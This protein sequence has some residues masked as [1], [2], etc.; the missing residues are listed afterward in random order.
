[1][2]RLNIA[3]IKPWWLRLFLLIIIGL[4]FFTNW[5][6]TVFD[7]EKPL[8]QFIVWL[9]YGMFIWIFISLN[10]GYKKLFDYLSF[11]F[12]LALIT[13]LIGAAF[14]H[15]IK[16][17]FN[18][19]SLNY[20]NDY[21]SNLI[22]IFLLIIIS[23]PYTLFFINCFSVS[24][25]ISRLS[26]S[27]GRFIKLKIHIAFFL[28]V[29]Q[30]TIEVFIELLE[31]WK[32]ENPEQIKPRFREDWQTSKYSILHWIV[33][34]KNTAITWSFGLLHNTFEAVQYIEKDIK[35]ILTKHGI[36]DE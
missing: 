3:N 15:F 33:W 35:I 27:S 21:S 2:N 30:H 13:I 28:R 20:T 14:R 11:A 36:K 9:G 31:I 16:L 19:F 1:M 34:F 7:L 18:E 8:S 4:P 26:L 32:E 10:I 6:L 23:I 29:F 5:N 22:N 17:I 12:P 24:A 25:F